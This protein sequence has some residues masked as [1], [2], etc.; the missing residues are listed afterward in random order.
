MAYA[1]LAQL[2]RAS[3]YGPEGRGFESLRAYQSHGNSLNFRG[4]AFAFCTFPGGSILRYRSDPSRDPYQISE[5]KSPESAGEEIPHRIR[6]LFL[7][8]GRD[9]GVGIEGKPG[10]V[11]AQHSGEGFYV[12]AVLQGQHRKCVAKV[13][14]A[15]PFQPRP[16]Q[17]PLKHV[18]DCQRQFEIVRKRRRNFVVFRRGGNKTKRFLVQKECSRFAVSGA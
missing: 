11:M 2:D 17:N 3:G 8:G 12:H 16:F 10:R 14:E 7:H 6:C 4:F 9:V 1:P 18:Q 15:D 13:V 5:R